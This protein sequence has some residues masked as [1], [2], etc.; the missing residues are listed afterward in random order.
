MDSTHVAHAGV[1]DSKIQYNVK[2][3]L[4]VRQWRPLLPA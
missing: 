4:Q 3:K 1:D 2:Y